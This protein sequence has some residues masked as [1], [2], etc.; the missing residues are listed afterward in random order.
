[1]KG[2]EPSPKAWEAFV[3]PLNYTRICWLREHHRGWKLALY[4]LCCVHRAAVAILPAALAVRTNGA[5]I[6][7]ADAAAVVA[8]KR[9]RVI[10]AFVMSLP[11]DVAISS[12][13]RRL[14]QCHAVADRRLRAGRAAKGEGKG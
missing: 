5:A 7:V 2:I 12:V 4:Q 1:M 3:L 6:I 9:R 14:I 11:P 13:F 8:T 10:L